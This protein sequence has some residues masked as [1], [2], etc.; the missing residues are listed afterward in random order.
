MTKPS[1]A[2]EVGQM[3]QTPAGSFA[4][5]VAIYEDVGEALVQWSS[6]DR[7]RFRLSQLRAVPGSP[8]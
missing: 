8:E 3:V 6:G 4:E 2:F 5:L 1:Q 7:A